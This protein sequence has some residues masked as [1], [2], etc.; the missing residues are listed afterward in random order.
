MMT[1]TIV[2]SWMSDDCECRRERFR[3]VSFVVVGQL[4]VV[5]SAI[6][7]VSAGRLPDVKW[8]LA[9]WCRPDE[10][11]AAPF[12]PVA[13]RCHPAWLL[14]RQVRDACRRCRPAEWPRWW[15]RRTPRWALPPGWYV[16][17]SSTCWIHSAI[18]ATIVATVAATVA[19][20]QCRLLYCKY[21]SHGV[22]TV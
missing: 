16:D 12:H 7:S 18:A 6:Q 3:G 5:R 19:Q 14:A 10:V 21:R 15:R 17:W 4:Q 11:D 9:A 8:T 22:F 1:E 20:L 2:C 13:T